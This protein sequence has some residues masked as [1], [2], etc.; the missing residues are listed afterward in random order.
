M[1]PQAIEEYQK[2]ISLEGETTS[3]LCYLGFALAMS[4]KRSEAQAILA[5]L[6]SGKEYVSP[7]ELAVLYVGLGDSEGALASLEKAYAEHDLQIGLLK[8]DPNLDSLRS[9]P[10]FQDLMRRVGLPQ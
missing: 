6:K 10:R 3:T 5:K 2:V 4:G 9:D 1:Y 7:A 8:V